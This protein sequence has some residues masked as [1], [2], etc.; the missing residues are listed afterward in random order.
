MNTRIGFETGARIGNNI[1]ILQWDPSIT[2]DFSQVPAFGQNGFAF[3]YRSQTADGKKLH[4][5]SLPAK[6]LGMESGNR[7]IRVY[8]PN[9][10]QIRV[11]RKADLKIFTTELPTMASLIE[12]IA[13]Q[14][15]IANELKEDTNDQAGS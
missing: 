5:R 12:G 15:Q 6:F 4:P 1:P 10:N 9:I 8:V 14:A 7:L 3:I 13:R 2:L 11:V